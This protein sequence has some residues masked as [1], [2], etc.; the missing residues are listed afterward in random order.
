[1]I[2]SLVCLGSWAAT[3]KM[4]GKWRFELYYV[5]FA[6]GAGLAVVIYTATVGSLGFD[7]FSFIDDMFHASKRFWI[8]AFGAGIVFNLANML[9]LAAVSVSGMA[10]AFPVGLGAGLLLGIG[11]PQFLAHEGQPQLVFLGIALIL[12]AMVV[13]ALAHGA[14]VAVRAQAILRQAQETKKRHVQAPRAAK[15][16]ILAGIAGLLMAAY[17]PLLEKSRGG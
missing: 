2:V 11:L 14:Q 1:M 10:V 15:G 8:F 12:A 5:D 7:G 13:T 6:F 17:E 4:T 3:Y 9:L 16:V